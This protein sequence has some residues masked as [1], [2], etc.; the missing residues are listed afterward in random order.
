MPQ[1]GKQTEKTT[2]QFTARVHRMKASDNGSSS[3]FVLLPADASAILPRRG[4]TTVRGKINGNEFQALL[5]P[6]GR[7][8]HWLSL[9]PALMEASGV[10]V[11]E[12]VSFEI[13]P[14]AEEPEP[15]VPDDLLEALEESPEARKTWEETTTLARVDWIHWIDSSRREATRR[16]RISDA[17][18]MLASGKKRVCCFDPS[19]YYSKGLCA[20][21]PA[22]ST[23][24]DN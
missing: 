18:D 19:G 2:A 13:E 17:C 14:V 22:T 21:E 4:R 20:P 23:N 8:S 16:S 24:R 11:G 7:K 3:A 10:A 15:D 12:E 1:I 5:E 6:D 9:D